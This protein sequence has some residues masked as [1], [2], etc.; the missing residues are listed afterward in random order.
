MKSVKSKLFLSYSLTIFI[1]LFLLSFSAL[2][3]FQENKEIKSLSLLETTYSNVENFILNKTDSEIKDLKTSKNIFIIINKN[4]NLLYSDLSLENNKKIISSIQ[5]KLEHYMDRDHEYERYIEVDD[6]IINYKTIN[7]NN[8]KYEVYI[9][10]NEF[11]LEEFL[12][13]I[14]ML[15]L[16][17]NIILFLILI[18]LGN[19]LIN[20]TIYP[21]KS[22]LADLARLQNKKDLSLRLEKQ[23]TNDEFENITDNLNKMLEWIENSVEN[24]KQFSSDAS[25]ELR[26]PLTIIQGEIELYKKRNSIDDSLN[27][28]LLKIDIEQKKLQN[29]ISDFLLLSRLDNEV[30][31]SELSFLDKIIFDVIEL[32]LHDIEKKNLKLEIDID[33]NI[34]IRFAEKYLFIIINNLVTNAIK[35]TTEGFIKIEAKK[36]NNGMY[37]FIEDT[38]IGISEKNVS[39]VFE[40]FFR[41]NEARSNSNKGIGLGLSIVKK[42]CER[43]NYNILINSE[44]N[45]GSKFILYETVK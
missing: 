37:F 21:L 34:E 19:F 29:I 10:V 6:Q 12:D 25:H 20:K 13:D 16:A 33:E 41:V 11:I 31:N 23:S 40:R 39:K 36:K 38:G 42:I 28:T 8:D 4:N 32:N 7:K 26:T 2:Y 35:Y 22:I 27:E 15:V 9:G 45:K 1:V 5:Y 24:T 3:L 44:L 14:Y 43:F 18:I 17:S 30:L